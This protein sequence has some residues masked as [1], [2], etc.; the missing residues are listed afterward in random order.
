MVAALHDSLAGQGTGRTVSDGSTNALPHGRASTVSLVVE[1]ELY[2][3]S[4]LALSP[5]QHLIRRS[6][7]S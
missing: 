1:L 7:R 3:D 2:P 5:W 6:E 4:D